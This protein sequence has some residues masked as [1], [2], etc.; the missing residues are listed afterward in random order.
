MAERLTLTQSVLSALPTYIMQTAWLPMHTCNC[1]DIIRRRLL[2]GTHN[3]IH[4][5]HLVPWV[6]VCQPKECGGLG[7]RGAQDYNC[8]LIM[9]LAWNYFADNGSL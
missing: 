8:A 4:R 1:L 9:K 7:L 2:W 6:R 3:A 5:I